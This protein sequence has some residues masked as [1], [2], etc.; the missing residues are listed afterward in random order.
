MVKNINTFRASLTLLLVVAAAS[1]SSL[2]GQQ[3]FKAAALLGANFS[4]IDG[5]DLAGY[6]KVGLSGGLKVAYPMYDNMDASIEMLYNVKGSYFRGLN[7]SLQYLDVPMVVSIKDWYQKE[8]DYHKVSAHGGLS[9]GYLFGATSTNGAYPSDIATYN[10]V[11][12]SYLIGVSYRFTKRLGLTVRHT[13][14][15]TNLLAKD[16]PLSGQNAIGYFV[17]ARTEFYF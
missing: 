2:T 15:F 9:I 3:R 7:L 5:D 16:G 1:F 10:Q 14:A 4:Q 8:A 6:D 11:D 17:T 13:R 12:V